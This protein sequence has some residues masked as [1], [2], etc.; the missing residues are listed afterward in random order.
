MTIPTPRPAA[1]LVVEDEPVVLFY[2]A[3]TIQNAGYEVIEATNADMAIEALKSRNDVK[4]LVTDIDMPGSMDGMRLAQAARD[5]S[6][7]IE[8]IVMSGKHRPESRDLPAGAI[9]FAKP[10]NEGELTRAL[11][12]FSGI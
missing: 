9:F 7:P 2:I 4:V 1:V 6:P 10:V 8:I 5:H 11:K 3:D 12:N